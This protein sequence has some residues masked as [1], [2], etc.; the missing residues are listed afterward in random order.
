MC[1]ADGYELDV[2]EAS[3]DLEL[4]QQVGDV[5]RKCVDVATAAVVDIIG[6][7]ADPAVVRRGVESSMRIGGT[8]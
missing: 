2:L 8:R 5:T 3:G 7:G 1:L 6:A 4:A